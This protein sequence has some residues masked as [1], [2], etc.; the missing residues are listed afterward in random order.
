MEADDLAMIIAFSDRAEVVSS[1]TGNRS[2]LRQRLR[3]IR[4]SQGTTSLREALEVAAGLANPSKDYAALMEGIVAVK[5]MVPP[6]LLIYTDGGFAD[7]EGFSI[8]KLEPEVVVI[9]PPPPPVVEIP[10]ARRQPRSL[11][12]NPSDNVAILALQC[13]RNEEFPD[14]VQVFGRVH[15]YRAEPVETTARLYRIEAG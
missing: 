9:G 15:N 12:T 11:R 6:K 14:Q 10:P 3:S 5:E 1:Y 8:G 2:L 13:S 4:P 7:V